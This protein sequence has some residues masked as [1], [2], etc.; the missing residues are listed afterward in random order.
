[1]SACSASAGAENEEGCEKSIAKEEHFA[2]KTFQAKI[3]EQKEGAA[4][5]RATLFFS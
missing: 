1:M 2:G 3:Q 5:I 4:K